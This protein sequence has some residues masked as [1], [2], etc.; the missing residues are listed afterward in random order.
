MKGSDHLSSSLETGPMECLKGMD[1]QEV[2]NLLAQEHPQVTALVISLIQDT[3]H[4]MEVLDAFPE[5][6][7][8][9]LTQ[10][11]AEMK[12]IPLEIIQMVDQVISQAVKGVLPH[13]K[14]GGVDKLV[15]LFL[16]SDRSLNSPLLIRIEELDPDLAQQIQER[17]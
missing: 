14:I 2:V 9:E 8:V 11:I 15:Q 6:F 4:A 12:T 7:Q 5:D 3:E 13:Q 16:S 10:R 17:L 1:P